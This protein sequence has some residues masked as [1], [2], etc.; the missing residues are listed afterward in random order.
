MGGEVQSAGL[1]LDQAGSLLHHPLVILIG[2][3]LP[4]EQV[5]VKNL[6][7]HF[8]CFAEIYISLFASN[9]FSICKTIPNDTR[10]STTNEIED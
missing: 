5:P 2:Y 7:L 1:L 3:Q 9:H 4:N 6:I 8:C 10:G